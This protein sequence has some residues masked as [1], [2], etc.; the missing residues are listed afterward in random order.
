MPLVRIPFGAPFASTVADHLVQQYTSPLELA[1]I[2]VWVPTTRLVGALSRALYQ[3]AGA[4]LLPTIRPL[5][6]TEEA[7]EEQHLVG[8]TSGLPVVSPHARL[9]FFARQVARKEPDLAPEHVLAAANS[10]ARLCDTLTQHNIALDQIRHAAPAELAHHWQENL[11]FLDIALNAYPA[12]LAETQYQDATTAQ[13]NWLHDMA[14]NIRQQGL[15]QPTYAVGFA[16]STPAGCQFLQAVVQAGGTLVLPGWQGEETPAEMPVSDDQAALADFMDRLGVTKEPC[17]QWGTA[18]ASSRTGLTLLNAE[19][20]ATAIALLLRETLQDP[21]ATCAVVTPDRALAR[22]VQAQA[23]TWQI[24]VDD[25]GGQPLT[26]TPAGRL[27]TAL[28][29]VATEQAMPVALARLLKQPGISY[30]CA[31]VL[32]FERAALRGIKPSHWQAYGSRVQQAPLAQELWQQLNPVLQTF[33]K[34]QYA[35]LAD[36]ITA[37]ITTLDQL[38]PTWQTLAGGAEMAALLQEQHAHGELMGQVR[39]SMLAALVQ[40]HGQATSVRPVQQEQTRAFI[41]GPL[42][43][44]GQTADHIIIAGC[45]EGT[46]PHPL[47]PHPWLNRAM[48]SKLGLPDPEKIWGLAAHDFAMLAHQPRVTFTRSAYDPEGE[49]TPSRFLVRAQAST[50]PWQQRQSEVEFWLTS[51]RE[52]GTLAAAQPANPN[53]PVT[54]RPTA[55]SASTVKALMQCP[56]QLYVHK[57]LQLQPLRQLEEPVDPALKGQLL[58][59][60]LQAFFVQVEGM[61]PP[62]AEPVTTANQPEAVAHLLLLGSAALTHVDTSLQAVWQPRM[63]IIAQDFVQHLIDHPHRQVVGCEVRAEAPCYGVTLSAIADR[64]EVGA[65]GTILVDYKT[66]GVPNGKELQE[67][68]EPQM[69]VEAW[70]QHHVGFAQPGDVEGMEFWKLSGGA[71]AIEITSVKMTED[72]L[73][74]VDQALQNMAEHYQQPAATYPAIP[75]SK[76][77]Q[78]CDHAGLCRKAEWEGQL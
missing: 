26:H 69:W 3:A 76:A 31:E 58:H 36:K 21:S 63:A 5:Q 27:V 24:Q 33:F 38:A 61:P 37:L 18:P 44:R 53:P 54:S 9:L 8:V 14:A 25:S 74:T 72:W 55:W 51:L 73:A 13:V 22:Q 30:A 70:L 64:V 66:G 23:Q 46:W 45:N 2:T 39:W 56:Y 1:Q 49:T 7:Q 20:E 17:T 19:Q 77:C 75:T 10:L 50:Q 42:E 40:H 12:W 52:Q 57:V 60:W 34:A 43:A 29:Q 4:T 68:I 62:F 28:L 65:Q 41:W 67:G 16:D 59:R 15:S 78:Y 6:L 11:A 48:F 32:A 47:K 35:N 71:S